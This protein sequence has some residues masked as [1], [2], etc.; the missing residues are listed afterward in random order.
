LNHEDTKAQ[1]TATEGEAVAPIDAERISALIAELGHKDRLVREA[2]TQSLSRMGKPGLEALLNACPDEIAKLDRQLGKGVRTGCVAWVVFMFLLSPLYL[3]RIDFPR[4]LRPG[5]ISLYLGMAIVA[6]AALRYGNRR[7]SIE[8]L[9]AS[10]EDPRVVGILLS[11]IDA[12][13]N[14][15][16]RVRTTL[17]RI[18]PL[19][20]RAEEAGLIPERLSQLAKS[21]NDKDVEWTLAAFSLLQKFGGNESLGHVRNA[22]LKYEVDDYDDLYEAAKRCADEIENRLTISRENARLLRPTEVPAESALLMPVINQGGIPD[23]QL[24]RPVEPN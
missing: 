1:S 11:L 17:L 13:G 16:K 24:V 15:D 6:N 14:V 22:Q 4:G 20:D 5:D 10:L 2:A 21:L 3:L 7:R 12:K 23:E 9:L 19:V 18:F 8:L